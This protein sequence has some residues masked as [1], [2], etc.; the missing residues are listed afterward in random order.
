MR[1]EREPARER[2]RVRE[3]DW[4]T[5]T[6]GLLLVAA[7]IGLVALLLAPVPE[8]VHKV[9]AIAG[10]TATTAALLLIITNL[11]EQSGRDIA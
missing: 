6:K 4:A 11:R 10:L 9:A 7:L 5:V 2:Q 1:P 8:P 3:I